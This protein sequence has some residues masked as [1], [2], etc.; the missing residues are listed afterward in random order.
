VI[1]VGSALGSGVRVTAALEQSAVNDRRVDVRQRSGLEEHRRR[2]GKWRVRFCREADAS[3]I[4][5]LRVLPRGLA[6][7]R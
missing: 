7:D 1:S 6:Q 4:G 3:Q 5:V 2:G